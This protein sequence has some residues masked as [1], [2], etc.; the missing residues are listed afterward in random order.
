MWG[1]SQLQLS[2]IRLLKNLQDTDCCG[3]PD[4]TGQLSWEVQYVVEVWEGR[5]NSQLVFHQQDMMYFAPHKT[6]GDRWLRLP[7]QPVVL[8]LCPLHQYY[9]LISW[10]SEWVVFW[11]SN[12]LKLAH[13]A[14][15]QQSKSKGGHRTTT[16]VG[17]ELLWPHCPVRWC[18]FLCTLKYPNPSGSN[19]PQTLIP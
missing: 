10:Q 7:T 9:F 5:E 4:C 19:P 2:Q 17:L 8:F 12:E 6:R 18:L 15:K 3:H 14:V 1:P 13:K 16:S 11:Q